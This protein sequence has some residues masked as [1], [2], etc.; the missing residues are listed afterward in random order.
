M[1]ESLA[2]I[3]DRHYGPEA[4]EFHRK[5]LGFLTE[6]EHL[7][8]GLRYQPVRILEL[9]VQTGRS[10]LIWRDYFPSAVVV[11]IDIDPEPE[12]IAGDPRIHFL[13]G[14]QDDQATLDAAG[15]ISGQ[16]FDIIIDDASHI[17]KL[18]RGSIYHLF[19]RWL[20]P[21][22]IYI[23]EDIS[24]AYT[25]LVLDGAP[26]EEVES[27]GPTFPSHQNGMVGVVKQLVDQAFGVPGKRSALGIERITA[28]SN[29]AVIRKVSP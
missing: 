1:P 20:K 23:I 13:R 27:D 15:A 29:M 14:S 18:T 9:G 19:P 2:A 7:F 26:F 10:L 16:G 6:Y 4:D 5:P 22:G 8:A 25:G 12:I 28:L 21:G 24:A 11:G 3:A 17:G